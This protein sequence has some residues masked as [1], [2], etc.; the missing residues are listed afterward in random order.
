MSD[1]VKGA[2]AILAVFVCFL[3]VVVFATSLIRAWYSL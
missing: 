2:I 3:G 1:P